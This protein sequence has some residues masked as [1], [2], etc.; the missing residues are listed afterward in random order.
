MSPPALKPTNPQDSTRGSASPQGEARRNAPA[1]R[2][3]AN[4][5]PGRTTG[6]GGRGGVTKPNHPTHRIPAP[7]TPAAAQ[8][9]RR[10]PYIRSQMQHKPFD[11]APCRAVLPRPRFVRSVLFP[12][13]EGVHSFFLFER[14]SISLRRLP[15]FEWSDA[16][17][18]VSAAAFHRAGRYVGRVA[19]FA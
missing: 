10:R 19:A 6:G 18:P 11:A 15:R 4:A 1:R 16:H 9:E 12:N 17:A 5:A 7:Q 2:S 14:R 13:D 3:K 8:A